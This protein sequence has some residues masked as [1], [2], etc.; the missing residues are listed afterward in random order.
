MLQKRDKWLH[1]KRNF[2][3]NDFV[4]IRD[5]DAKRYKWRLGLVSEVHPSKKD[6]LVRTVTV[7][8]AYGKP[9]IR[10][11]RSLCFLEAFPELWEKELKSG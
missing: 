8:Q 3:I 10:D 2:Q 9:L 7:K 5:K 4:L 6:G 11:I 1:P